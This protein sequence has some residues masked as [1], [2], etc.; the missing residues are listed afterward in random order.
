MD[1][2]GTKAQYI[3]THIGAIGNNYYY[4]YGDDELMVAVAKLGTCSTE[5]RKNGKKIADFDGNERIMPEEAFEKLG[6]PCF[7][8]RPIEKWEVFGSP[9]ESNK[10]D[11][12]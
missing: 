7:G 1:A 11:V 12:K 8:E 6:I 2:A 5:V 3:R 4:Q 10:W 9:L